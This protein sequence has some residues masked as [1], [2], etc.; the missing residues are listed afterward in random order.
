[1]M[2]LTH[3]SS[4]ALLLRHSAS[5]HTSKLN[6]VGSVYSVLPTRYLPGC[7]G[8]RLLLRSSRTHVD[9]AGRSNRP[10]GQQLLAQAVA[11]SLRGAF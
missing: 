7:C 9:T 8:L 4:L 3:A 1:M 10:P 5:S 2:S 11:C 6:C